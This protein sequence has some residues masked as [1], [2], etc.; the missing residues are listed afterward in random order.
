MRRMRIAMIISAPFP[1][2]EGIGFHVWHLARTLLAGGHNVTVITR[3]SLTGPRR[4]TVDRIPVWRVPFW[5]L[6]PFH[7]HWHGRFVNRLLER[8]APELDLVHL[9]TPLVRRPRTML[10]VVVTVH[11]PIRS[12]VAAMPTHSPLGILARCQLPLSVRLETEL[13]RHAAAVTAVAGRVAADL[14]PYGVDPGAVRVVGNGV[15]T[16]YFRPDGVVSTRPDILTVGRL[17]PGKGMGDLVEC[18]A[19]VVADRPEARFRIAGDGPL[20]RPLRRRVRALGLEEHVTLL[21]HIGE[22]ARLRT[23]YREAAVCVHPARYEGMP[24]AVLEAMAC[25]RPVVAAAAGGLIEAVQHGESGLLV[26]PGAPAEL[27][28]GVLTLLDRPMLA[29]ELGAAARLAA[30]ERYSWGA[31]ARRILAVYGEVLG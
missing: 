5:P 1:P 25:G 6:Y 26:R 16:T 13:L 27:A 3:G 22:R 4:E 28:E 10:P 24:T 29:W 15:D 30:V 11:S 14:A 2:R 12:G 21:G 8:L 19:R 31:V 17:A 7:V 18:A 20:A 9:H 23:L